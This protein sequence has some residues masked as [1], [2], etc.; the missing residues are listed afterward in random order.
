MLFEQNTNINVWD[1]EA[2]FFDVAL[3]ISTGGLAVMTYYELCS[4]VM[5]L[6]P[7]L[8]PT[9]IRLGAVQL[10]HLSPNGWHEI[11]LYLQSNAM[12]MVS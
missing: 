2:V 5:A 8:I 6:F 4:A 11:I 1:V 10:F 9:A 12:L 3:I 7:V